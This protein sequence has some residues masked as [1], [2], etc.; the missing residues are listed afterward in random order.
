ML[1]GVLSALVLATVVP[2]EGNTACPRP[3]PGFAGGIRVWMKVKSS[4]ALLP[5]Q[6]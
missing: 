2:V 4:A 6:F 5:P 3:Q 1:V